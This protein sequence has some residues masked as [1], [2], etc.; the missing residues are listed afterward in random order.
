VPTDKRQRHKEGRS[1]RREAAIA[2]A[3]RRQRRRRVVQVTGLAAAVLVLAL[4]VS[5]FT[6][7]D[8]TADVAT[9]PACEEASGG[10]VDI[11]T[12][13]EVKVPEGEPPTA[14]ACTD[15]VVG[16]GD[17]AEE[18]DQVQMKYVGVS[19]STGE[20]FDASWGKEQDTF[21]V[22]LGAGEVIPGWDQGIPGMKVGGRRELVIPP[23]LAYGAEGRP[24]TIA[25]NDTLVFVVDLVSVTKA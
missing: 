4:L 18:G 10:D 25:P 22:T 1:A 13:P 3:R 23:D 24:P 8:E 7:D 21:P 5:L 15:I 9:G 2:E 6:K 16:D 20:E 19:S 17:V 11:S 12:K 14:L